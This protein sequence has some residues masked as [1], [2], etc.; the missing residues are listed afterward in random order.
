MRGVHRPAMK[1]ILDNCACSILQW[2]EGDWRVNHDSFGSF[3]EI[4]HYL[5]CDPEVNCQVSENFS[6]SRRFSN[7][8]VMA[9]C[10]LAIVI[11]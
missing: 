1:G 10:E 7:H 2:I 3:D 6:P 9:S 5:S 8:A 4:V 11:G